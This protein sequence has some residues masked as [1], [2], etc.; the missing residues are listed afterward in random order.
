MSVVQIGCVIAGLVIGYLSSILLV[1]RKKK[2]Q[3]RMYMQTFDEQMEMVDK[4]EK[5][6]NSKVIL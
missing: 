2:K 1:G 4:R 3:L 5:Q 6:G